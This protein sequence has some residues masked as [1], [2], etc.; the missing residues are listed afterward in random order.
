MRIVTCRPL[1]EDMPIFVF[2]WSVDTLMSDFK[3]LKD[4]D[5]YV[6]IDRSGKH[7]QLIL[8]FLRDGSVVLP[9]CRFE[10]SEILAEAK[11]YLIKVT[12]W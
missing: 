12:A 2:I 6:M 1:H 7:F 11:Y 10:T 5:G 4:E 8:N 9:Q 3:V